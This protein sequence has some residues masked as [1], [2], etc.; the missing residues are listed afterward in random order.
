MK[1]VPSPPR[2]ELSDKI[3]KVLRDGED[4]IND[5]FV[6]VEVLDDKEMQEI[7]DEYNF[8]NVKNEF[9]E[10]KV[11]EILEFFYGGEDNGKFRIN[12]EML[13]SPHN[14]SDFI[15]FLCSSEGEQI[16]Q[17]NSMLIH[18]ESRNLFY[19]NFNTQ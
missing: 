10:G 4:I 5:E 2:L 7:K 6:K 1:S 19:D 12:S 13:G 9:D 15:K 11:P 8:D 14:N 16:M 3:L 17:E 18:L